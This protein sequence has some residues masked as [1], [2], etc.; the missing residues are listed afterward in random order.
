MIHT[1]IRLNWDADNVWAGASLAVRSLQNP[2]CN[3]IWS[4]TEIRL[5]VF[6]PQVQDQD[7]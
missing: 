3:N 4:D 6:Y 5:E 2:A 1:V 7:Q